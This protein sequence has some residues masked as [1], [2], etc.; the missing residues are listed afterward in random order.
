MNDTV[1]SEPVDLW[2]SQHFLT[3]YLMETFKQLKN[4]NIPT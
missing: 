3:V 2:F 4:T 1:V